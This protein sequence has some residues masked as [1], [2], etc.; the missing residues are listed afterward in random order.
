MKYYINT[1]ITGV[2]FDEAIDRTIEAL[3]KEGFGVLTD[4]DIKAT[5]KK[6]L[7]VDL[8]NYRIL[9]ACN[10]GYAYKALQEENKIGTML[11]CNVI[12]QENNNGTIEISAVDPIASMQAVENENLGSLAIGIK[13]K[14][15]KVIDSL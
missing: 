7:D 13:N 3:K 11:P 15:Q 14:L 2:T 12:V 8:N 6:K 4:I 1:T 9:G 10:P 5:M